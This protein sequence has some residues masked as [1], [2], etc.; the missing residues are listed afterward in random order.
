MNLLEIVKDN[1][2]SFQFY[3]QGYLYYTITVKGTSY[4]FPIEMTDL[5]TATLNAEEKAITLMR[6]IRKALEAESFV[7]NSKQ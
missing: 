2:A 7:L 6:Y 3:R 1:T 5:G 4:V